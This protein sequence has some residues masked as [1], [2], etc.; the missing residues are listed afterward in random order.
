MVEQY[1]F[2]MILAESDVFKYVLSYK[3]PDSSKQEQVF[4]ANILA[5]DWKLKNK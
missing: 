4:L 3:T 1:L 2:W 5:S